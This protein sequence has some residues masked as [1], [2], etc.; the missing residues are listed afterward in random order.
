MI[1]AHPR[2]AIPF[3][4]HLYN[5]FYP[6]LRYYGDLAGRRNR[7]RLV[8]DILA[9]EVMRDWSPRPD[10]QHTL[11]AIEQYDFNG[12]VDAILRA[13]T[14]D[15]GKQRWGEKTP[16]HAFWWPQI[17]RG[18]PD[19]QV[20]HIV[21]DGRDVALSWFRARFGPKHYYPLATEWV[22][23]L[24]TIDD[25]RAALPEKQFFELHYE[26]LLREP[27]RILWEICDFLEEDY[28]RDMLAFHNE[29]GE[30]RTDAGNIENLKK[31]ILQGNVGKWKTDMT[32][33]QLRIF[34][35]VAGSML[36]KF[37][38]QRQLQKPMISRRERLQFKYLEHPPR[39]I[40][41]MIKNSK[42]H[43]DGLRRAVIYLRLR[44][45]APRS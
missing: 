17:L 20:V 4:S 33:H 42:G 6:W 10:R 29:K 35:A 27:D 1:G 15:V 16:P 12:V 5:T 8:D 44:I 14:R 13:W 37:G 9:T 25:L 38:Y 30:Y 18:F 19:M 11:D 40:F 2:I 23:Y 36:D 24:Q 31:P 22:R 7:E 39:K 21:R 41:A 28:S 43:I 3:E 26:D 45:Q 32:R 34:E